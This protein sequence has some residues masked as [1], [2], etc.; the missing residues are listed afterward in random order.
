MLK[1]LIISVRPKQ[2]YKNILLFVGIVFSGNI[3]NASM[4]STVIL[5]FIYFCM[6]AGAEYLLND[7]IDRERDKKHPTKSQRPI[8][9]GQLSVKYAL[10]FALLLIL[11]SL[12]AA[13]Y[14]V[15]FHFFNI[16]GSYLILVIVYSLIVKHLIIADVL[17]VAAGFVLRA[18]GGAIA[19][20][21]PASPWLIICTFLLAMFLALEK[22]W[23]ELVAL[24]DQAEVHRPN[25]AEYSPKL[26]E[27]LVGITTAS[28]IVSYLLYTFTAGNDIMLLTAPF[29]IYGLF[30]YLYLVHTRSFGSETEMI[31]KDKGMVICLVL[32]ALLVV[33]I[34]QGIP[35][36]VTGSVGATQ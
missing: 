26:L 31:F 6:L 7:I 4:W 35:E 36:I 18:A 3:L 30:R 9:S 23:S 17:V 32:W 24:T 27:Q 12:L 19:I 2:W 8:A 5:A 20:G 28:L 14:T 34:L 22:R 15:G 29:A 13:Y 21:V 33:L 1:Y 16:L 10:L 11:L 25:L